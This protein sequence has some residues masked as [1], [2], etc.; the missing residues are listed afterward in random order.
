MVSI[1]YLKEMTGSQI[2]EMCVRAAEELPENW[3]VQYLANIMIERPAMM[4]SCSTV[5]AGT[6]TP[7]ELIDFCAAHSLSICQV[8]ES[9]DTI[10]FLIWRRWK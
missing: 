8:D 9:A 7:Q 5:H 1:H 10:C 4:L 2:R 6:G 3:N